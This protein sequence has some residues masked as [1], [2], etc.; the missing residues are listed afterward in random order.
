MAYTKKGFLVAASEAS[1]SCRNL[2]IG[3]SSHQH[4]QTFLKYAIQDARASDFDLNELLQGMSK[5]ERETLFSYMLVIVQTIEEENL[6]SAEDNEDEDSEEGTPDAS[7]RLHAI[8]ALAMKL[9]N[10]VMTIASVFLSDSSR[11]A[12]QSLLETMMVLHSSLFSLPGLE[13]AA[14]QETI[15][16][17]CEQWWC[18]ERPGA[19]HLVT[20]TLV[21]LLARA[22]DPEGREADIKRL[23]AIRGG[24][25]LLDW[26]DSDSDTIRELVLRAFISP[27][28][29]RTESGKR[30]LA[31]AFALHKTFTKD[32][33]TVVKAQIPSAQPKITAA[34]KPL[35]E[36]YGDVY[37]RAWRAASEGSTERGEIE[38]ICIQDLMHA[39]IHTGSPGAHESALLVLTTGFHSHKRV[40]GV[41]A[42]LLK[43]YDPILWRSLSAANPVVRAQACAALASAF[44][45][46]NPDA[47]AVGVSE[48]LQRQFN[49]LCSLLEDDSPQVRCVTARA[50]CRVLG[51]WWEAIPLIT[52]QALLA[53][54]AGKLTA[55]AS[56]SLVRCAAI[57]GLTDLLDCP[58]SHSCMKALLP[59]LR[60]ALHDTSPRVRLA[61][62][63]LLR[64]VRTVKAFKFF[65][66]APVDHILQRLEASR[67]AK[68]K[69]VASAI[70][71]LLLPSYLPQGSGVTGEEQVSRML[72]M[73]EQNAGA[74]GI[75]CSLV[76]EHAGIGPATKLAVMLMR[77]VIGALDSIPTA[78]TS[79]SR[80]ATKRNR[81]GQAV[82]ASSTASTRRKRRASAAAD[83][84]AESSEEGAKEGE[85][86]DSLHN[87]E[88]LES[89]LIVVGH[90]WSAIAPQ[91]EAEE[92]APCRDLLH[93][94]VTPKDLQK[95]LDGFRHHAGPRVAALR[96]AALAGKGGVESE[97]LQDL[98]TEL[99]ALPEDAPS[100]E[101][102][103][104]VDLL[105]AWGEHGSLIGVIAASLEREFKGL[106]PKTGL[107][108]A[109]LA[110]GMLEHILKGREGAVSAVREGC[111]TDPKVFVRLRLAL[112]AAVEEADR[113]L[114]G[115]EESTRTP[116]PMPLL[117]LAVELLGRL[118]LHAAANAEDPVVDGEEEGAGD[119]EQSPLQV[120]DSMV[121]LTAWVGD[122]ILPTLV[123]STVDSDDADA[124]KRQLA[125]GLFAVVALL[126]SEWV[127]LGSGLGQMSVYA[128]A[129]GKKLLAITQPRAE[130]DCIAE[131]DT[132]EEEVG[133]D[134]TSSYSCPTSLLP[135][136]C[137]LVYQLQA[138]EKQGAHSPRLIWSI[139][140]QSATAG[141]GAADVLDP[142]KSSAT[143]LAATVP[144]CVK[145]LIHGCLTMQGLGGDPSVA[146]LVFSFVCADAG[147]C[148]DANQHIEPGAL[149]KSVVI[150]PESE[151]END[152]GVVNTRASGRK[153]KELAAKEK[154]NPA[155]TANDAQQHQSLLI[156]RTAGTEV[157]L[158]PQGAVILAVVLSS[159][160]ATV[161][162]SAAM[163]PI[164][165]RLDGEVVSKDIEKQLVVAHILL[166]A[167]AA[168]GGALPKALDKM[169]PLAKGVVSDWRSHLA[170]A[171]NALS[172]RS[173]ACD[174]VVES[175]TRHSEKSL[176]A[177]MSEVLPKLQ[178]VKP[179]PQVLA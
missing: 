95:L 64:H 43:L 127:A 123:S 159:V 63:K 156:L 116:T 73:I 56:S 15:S 175:S 65:K 176:D 130:V 66:V 81:K 155:A 164:L 143:A 88:S 144:S 110:L 169:A 31:T 22:L 92:N 33:H 142:E 87:I 124:Q 12:P 72:T 150:T 134:T 149:D 141:A 165:R 137:R 83:L 19:E 84:D 7:D 153:K 29:L 97:L 48:V 2:K 10:G 13:G 174:S 157:S 21:Y 98:V 140:L 36:A 58:L 107:P 111:V 177:V 14:L 26:D 102:G 101:Y 47:G 113:Q 6:L 125:E 163:F 117:I 5:K 100:R 80:A 9:L 178:A 60:G 35:L 69:A 59:P 172:D 78:T 132:E 30:F 74:A 146:D 45:L 61:F 17:G 37:F 104:I 82:I 71:E 42:T 76:H 18:S 112:N 11:V 3:T 148:V 28:F 129:W 23:W 118:D 51:E 139:I 55:D 93:T 46:Q 49:S 27:L 52:T 145:R 173:N 67:E 151:E 120:G 105:C 1:V 106:R 158:Q 152:E 162:L 79:T 57:E 160:P 32:I 96:V 135:P 8:P 89:V 121:K 109:R 138:A 170:P 147:V 131:N 166:R 40:R 41:D 99:L 53:R 68:D 4:F 77:V 91:L 119:R 171:V 108:P 50:V 115:S 39:C 54:V 136:L 25:L 34:R 94:H 20:H 90:L 86:D 62:V 103:P 114:M 16:R 133:T 24:L 44:P 85:Q 126:A 70:T 179:A 167:L 168:L 161:S 122:R 154:A 38:T 75:F 128:E